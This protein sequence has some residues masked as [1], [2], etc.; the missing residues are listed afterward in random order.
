V[1]SARDV[2]DHLT[3]CEDWPGERPRGPVLPRDLL[4]AVTSQVLDAV[5]AKSGWGPARI[6]VKAGVEFDTVMSCLGALAAA[7]FVERCE[8]GWRIRR[9]QGSDDGPSI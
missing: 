3:F 7:G 5:P 8:R 9:H 1:T 2:V 4:D 6:A